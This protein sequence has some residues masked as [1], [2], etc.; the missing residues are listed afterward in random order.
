MW[1]IF[2]E[3][4]VIHGQKRKVTKDRLAEQAS[5]EIAWL[6]MTLDANAR[7]ISDDVVVCDNLLVSLY[8]NPWG[9]QIIKFTLIPVLAVHTQVTSA[10]HIQICRWSAAGTRTVADWYNKGIP[11]QNYNI[12]QNIEMTPA[13]DPKHIWEPLLGL[14]GEPFGNHLRSFGGQR[15]TMGAQVMLE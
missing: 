12:H 2:P 8:Y 5:F 7:G 3:S 15:V 10:Y 9:P 6:A 13:R 1:Q 4:L 14:F 11:E